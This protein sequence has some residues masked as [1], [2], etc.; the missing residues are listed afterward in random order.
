V[1]MVDKQPQHMAPEL[2]GRSKQGNPHPHSIV[3]GREG[4]LHKCGMFQ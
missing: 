1:A 4:L 2:S 3:A